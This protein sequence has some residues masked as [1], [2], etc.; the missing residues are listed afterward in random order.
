M[1]THLFIY[2]F[3]Y[4][5]KINGE[6][7][8]HNFINN[9]KNQKNNN[10]NNKLKIHLFENNYRNDIK[11]IILNQ[12]I[13]SKKE[14]NNYFI[15]SFMIYFKVCDLNEFKQY[16]MSEIIRMLKRNSSKTMNIFYYIL[17]YITF[18]TNEFYENFIPLIL[19]ELLLNN[20][21]NKNNNN[22]ERINIALDVFRLYTL[23][24]NNFNS[25]ISII[26]LM[27]KFMEKNI[28][29]SI[30]QRLNFI[31]LFNYL[32]INPDKLLN[33]DNFLNVSYHA[34]NLLIL[35]LKK[36]SNKQVRNN[37]FLS[38]KQ[39]IIALANIDNS[40]N[41]QLLKNN[42]LFIKI[43]TNLNKVILTSFQGRNHGNKSIASNCNY[44]ID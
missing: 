26:H 29:N 10:N 33:N 25:F 32:Y 16:F 24:C 41:N 38:M 8:Y 42:D 19:N 37:I 22:D 43:I 18:D 40:N 35:L 13:C 30:Q 31:K 39:W 7:Y 1:K 5:V 28:L 12:I 14:Y 34:I 44:Y 36:E 27:N 6:T 21:D 20:N 9:E 2:L 23:H 17:K 11:D 3:I 4:V 15:E